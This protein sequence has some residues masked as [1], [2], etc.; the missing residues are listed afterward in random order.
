MSN[1]PFSAEETLKLAIKIEENG[2]KFHERMAAES[3]D[4]EL[5]ELFDK[6]A[7]QEKKHKKTF[8]E[9]LGETLEEE[10]DLSALLYGKLEDSYLDVLADSKV[11]TSANENI[12]AAKQAN[13]RGELL[14]IAI[15]LAKDKILYYYELLDK[16]TSDRDREIIEGIIEQ[17]KSLIKLLANSR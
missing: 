14:G 6:L 2:R 12:R 10:E 7:E 16:A 17:E 1:I 4:E 3:D 5:V 9:M 11:F 15:S 13:N 8:E